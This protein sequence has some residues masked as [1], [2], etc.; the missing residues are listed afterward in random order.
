[1]PVETENTDTDALPMLAED[2][3]EPQVAPQAREA[4]SPELPDTQVIRRYE[5]TH[6]T[7]EPWCATCVRI[8]EFHY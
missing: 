4:P 7:M 3:R 8:R 5:L 6:A 2:A 1:M